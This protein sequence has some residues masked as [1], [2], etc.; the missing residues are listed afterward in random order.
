MQR[1]DKAIRRGCF[2]AA[3]KHDYKN[4]SAVDI[5]N[6]IELW[7]HDERDR[8]ILKRVLLD[9]IHYEALAEEMNISVSTVRRAMDKHE[10]TVFIKA[11]K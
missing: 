4:I 11:A 8:M 2:F 9:G 6:T 10:E 1:K 5:S 3:M 7:V